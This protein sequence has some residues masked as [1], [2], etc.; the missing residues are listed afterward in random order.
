MGKLD[1]PFRGR[2]AVA[3]GLLTT[4]DLRKDFVVV[5]RG[6]Y[7]RKGTAISLRVRTEAAVVWSGEPV[8]VMGLAAAA[9]HGSKWVDDTVPISLNRPGHRVPSGIVGSNDQLCDAEVCERAGMLVATAARVAFDLGRTLPPE[10]AIEALDALFRATQLTVAD[11]EAIADRHPGLRGLRQLRRV[12]PLVDAEAESPRE[13]RTRLLLIRS[14]LP[15]PETQIKFRDA[16]GHVHTRLDM[17]YREWKVG[18]EYDGEQHWTDRR[19]RARDIDRLAELED[20]GWRIVHVSAE[21]LDER[22][23]VIVARVRAAL[24]A[25]RLQ[26]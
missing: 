14:G 18:V 17:G 19:Q 15:R 13:T 21:L 26:Q 9:L 6:V 2:D 20:A 8:V 4:H 3:L 22:P 11:V 24:A 25:A 5:F 7:V 23:A 12:L 10:S 1:R 16:H